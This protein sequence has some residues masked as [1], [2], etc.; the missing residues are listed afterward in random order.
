MIH[1]SELHGLITKVYK[2]IKSHR[3]YYYEV[4][5]TWYSDTVK[6][7]KEIVS[8]RD[9]SLHSRWPN[10]STV[11][12][13]WTEHFEQLYQVDPLTVNLEAGSAEILLLDP[14]ISEVKGAI[15]KLKSGKDSGICGIRAEMLKAGGEPMARE[16]CREFRR[17]LLTTYIDLKKAY[18]TVH[19]ESLWEIQRLKRIPKR[20]IGLISSLYI[21]TKSAAK[22][23]EDLS[24]FPVRSRERQS[25]L[26]TNTSQHM[27]ELDTGQNYCPKSWWSNIKVT[28]FDFADVAILWPLETLLVTL[29]AFSNEAI[30][31]DLEV[32]WTKTKIQ[33]FSDLIGESV[34]SICACGKDI[35][36]PENFTYLGS[37]VHNSGL[38][39]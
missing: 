35:E 21:G 28:D 39:V 25:C 10:P 14:P 9:C 17:E 34:R 33:E 1:K 15:S 22:C 36:V 18:D 8:T 23:G 13:L 29:D 3:F 20:I 6:A 5:W 31:L 32:S 2:D 30:P 27:H 37:L 26:H 7:A 24:S 38:S 11:R 19:R 4:R 16:H 12:E